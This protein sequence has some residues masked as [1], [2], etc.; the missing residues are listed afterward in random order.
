[1]S[2][3][4]CKA[5][6]C[7]ILYLVSFITPSNLNDFLFISSAEESNPGHAHTSQTFYHWAI[8]P[9]PSNTINQWPGVTIKPEPGTMHTPTTPGI[10]EGLKQ[11]ELN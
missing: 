1:M 9:L 10:Q 11:E 2:K 7:D 3:N 8:L 5:I 6:L 4:T